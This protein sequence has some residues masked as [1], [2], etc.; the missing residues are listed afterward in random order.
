MVLYAVLA[1]SSRHQAITLG[2]DE[3]E[4][5][6][7]HGSCLKL[8]ISV[9]SQPEETWDDNLLATIVILRIYEEFDNK[10]DEKCHLLGSNR[11]LNTVSNFSSSGGLAEAA[12]WQFLRQAIYISLVYQVPIELNLE[13]YERS[14]VFNRLDNASYANVI[15]FLFAKALQ[16]IYP[17][18]GVPVDMHAWDLLQ[19][20]VER[21][22]NLKPS[23]FTPFHYQEPSVEE[24]R[25]FPELWMISPAAGLAPTSSQYPPA[26]VAN[27]GVV[28]GM[29][30][31]HATRIL[32]TMHKPL[33]RSHAG[34]QAARLMRISEV[35]IHK[36]S[37]I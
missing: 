19:E 10:N 12:S 36:K 9:L 11:L 18:R 23:S 30:Y 26:S 6:T 3:V 14:S 32:L 31:Y 8:L 20:S 17:P 13:N 28:V 2:T 16:L 4:A 21:W 24:S 27:R 35:R 29:Q 33:P 37:L 7:F 25:P 22:Q 5:S 34:F 15:I 1:A